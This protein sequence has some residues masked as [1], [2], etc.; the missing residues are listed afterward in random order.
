M[1]GLLPVDNGST[2]TVAWRDLSHTYDSEDQGPNGDS[3]QYPGMTHG[4][5]QV[6]T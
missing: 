3:H 1:G 2:R 6:G 4:S 5:Q